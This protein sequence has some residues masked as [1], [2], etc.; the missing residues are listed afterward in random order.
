MN[1]SRLAA[2]A[3]AIGASVVSLAAQRKTLPYSAEGDYQVYC[4]SCHGTMA[5]GDGVI[6]NSLKKRPPDLTQLA[7]RNGG[8]FPEEKVSKAI[9]G[10]RNGHADSDMP[11]WADVLAKSTDSLGEQNAAARINLLVEYLQTLQVKR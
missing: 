11:A 6:A 2:L 3:L 7:R 5:K 8:V 4:S 9:D 10:R 1:A